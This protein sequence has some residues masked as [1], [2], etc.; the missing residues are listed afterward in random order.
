MLIVNSATLSTVLDLP[1]AAQD[2]A[3]QEAGSTVV[4][5]QIALAD[6]P[7]ALIMAGLIVVI[8]AVTR[9]IFAFVQMYSSQA[10]SQNIAFD[11]RNDLFS[12]DPASQLQLSRQEPHRPAHDSRHGRRGKAAPVPRPGLL[13]ALQAFI[14]LTGT[15]IILF[16]TN[17]Q[18]TWSSCPCCRS[19]S[20]CSCSSA[21]KRM[22]LFSE[23]QRRLSAVNTIL[24]E[25]LAGLKVVK[26]FTSE[27]REEERFEESIDD[28]LEQQMQVDAL[29]V[30]SLPV[31]LPDRQP[32]PGGHPLFRRPGIIEGTLTLGEWQK[33]SLYLTFVFIPMGQLGMI[34]SLMAQATASADR[35]FRDSGHQERGGGQAG[36]RRAGARSNGRVA[37]KMSPSATSSTA[38]TC[39]K[40]VSFVAE[41]GQ[42]VALLGST[43]SGKIDD[44]QPHPA[45]L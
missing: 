1:P 20:C 13:M 23:V 2:A 44:H 18:L 3:A 7:R 29:P 6:A 14:L 25:N 36:R 26:S 9:G 24:Q 30:L 43:G 32:R 34:I 42:T 45:L 38:S 8:F 21:P 19:P 33:F 5:M 22:P 37:F 10:L 39:C 27:E 35:I 28:L 11:L 16:L 31:H 41:P 17:W 12:Q 4:Q 15:L 40:T